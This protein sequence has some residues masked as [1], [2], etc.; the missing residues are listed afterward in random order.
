MAPFSP[1]IESYWQDAFLGSESL[2]RNDTLTITVK[3]DLD[4]DRRVM[5]LKTA[6]GQCMAVCTPTLAEK[7]GLYGEQELSE[8]LLRQRLG[9]NQVAL[10][11][12]DYVFHFTEA[13]KQLLLQEPL[14]AGLRQ[15]GA[16]DAAVPVTA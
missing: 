11:G 10:H 7:L 13:D 15:L 4:E 6:A 9:D 16:A 5:L 12:A 2:Y 3:P 14:A 8:A 1:T